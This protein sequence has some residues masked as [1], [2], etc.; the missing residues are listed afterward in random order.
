MGH[1][2]GK[3][4]TPG[5]G[6]QDYETDPD[7]YAVYDHEFRFGLDAAA[8]EYNHKCKA[9]LTIEDNSLEID[10]LKA[11]RHTKFGINIWLN[12]PYGRGIIQAFMQKCWETSQQGATVV[13]LVHTT[14]DTR[15]WDDWVWDKAAE[16]RHVKGRLPFW[17]NTPDKH[18]KYGNTSDLPHSVIIWRP[19]YSGPTFQ[20]S[21]D[22]KKEYFDRI[23]LLPRRDRKS[24]DKRIIEYYERDGSR[25]S[26]EEA[27]KAA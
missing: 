11:A 27:G 17:S 25:I 13:A 22:W 19:F 26:I 21:W 6:K 1:Q 23:G 2:P 9:Y 10:W 15:Y 8:S 16:V 3:D 5:G 12:P 14:T 18:G 4:R 20:T 24:K 7:F